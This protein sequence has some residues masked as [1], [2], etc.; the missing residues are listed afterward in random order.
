M[1]VSVFRRRDSPRPFRAAELSA[2]Q[3]LSLPATGRD[4]LAPGPSC[5]GQQARPRDFIEILAFA[6]PDV[7]PR[8][9]ED[10]LMKL[11]AARARKQGVTEAP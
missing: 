11:L 5:L 4:A 10:N 8:A 7:F 2:S 9:T 3:S 6:F 1:S